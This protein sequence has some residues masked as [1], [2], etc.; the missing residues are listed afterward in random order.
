MCSASKA[1][2]VDFPACRQQSKMRCRASERR[3]SACH[4]SGAIPNCWARQTG[5]SAK[6]RSCWS[7]LPTIA[8]LQGEA[9]WKKLEELAARPSFLALLRLEFPSQSERFG[10]ALERRD[11]LRLMGAS[12]GL[13]GFTA[14]SRQPRRVC[15][16]M[17][18]RRPA[19]PSASGLGGVGVSVPA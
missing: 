2:T 15:T 1:D 16:S 5:S 14:C 13:A 9:Y 3:R 11:F 6:A 10:A 12:R 7:R 18:R 17:A 19:R 8:G 4:G